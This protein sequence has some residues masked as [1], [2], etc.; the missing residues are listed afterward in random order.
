MA[1]GTKLVC[2]FKTSNDKTISM[3]F[4]YAKSN[5]TTANVKT[6]MNTIIANG[7]IFANVPVYSISAKTQ[8]TS[9]NEF[10]L[11]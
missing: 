10:N 6:L 5:A 4:N 1:S 7:A 9:E 2:T 3:T 8:T 11:D